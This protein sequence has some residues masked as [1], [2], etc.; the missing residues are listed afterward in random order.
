MVQEGSAYGGRGPTVLA[1]AHTGL[2]ITTILI[3]GR[4]Y[5]RVAKGVQKERKHDVGLWFTLFSWVIGPPQPQPTRVI[6]I[7]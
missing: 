5:L 3:A 7:I 2:A 1:V 4:V 6:L